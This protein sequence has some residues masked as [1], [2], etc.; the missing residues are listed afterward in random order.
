MPQHW[1]MLKRQGADSQCPLT[2]LIRS[3]RL[4]WTAVTNAACHN[5]GGVEQHLDEDAC[6]L[7]VA[8]VLR[9]CFCEFHECVEYQNWSVSSPI[10]ESAKAR[11]SRREAALRTHRC[12][13]VSSCGS[14]SQTSR[15][16]LDFAAHRTCQTQHRRLFQMPK[17]PFVALLCQKCGNALSSRVWASLQRGCT[18]GQGR[19]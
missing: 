14:S 15:T 9:R 10:P 1:Q 2:T 19:R 12:R 17:K 6:W 16:P 8:A 11:P 5:S 7:W 18:P 13:C 3:N 4:W